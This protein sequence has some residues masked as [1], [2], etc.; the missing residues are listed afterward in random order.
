MR[1]NRR[2]LGWSSENGLHFGLFLGLSSGWWPLLSRRRGGEG[3]EGTELTAWQTRTFPP[4]QHRQGYAPDVTPPL[5]R[6][7]AREDTAW[8]GHKPV[9]EHH[10]TANGRVDAQASKLSPKPLAR[11]I[12]RVAARRWA[13][14]I[15]HEPAPARAILGA[16]GGPG[17]RSPIAQW[18]TSSGCDARSSQGRADA[19]NYRWQIRL[20][21]LRPGRRRDHHRGDC[22]QTAN[23]TAS[24][25][26][27]YFT[28]VRRATSRDRAVGVHLFDR[29]RR[30]F[31]YDADKTDDVT[32]AR[33]RQSR[34]GAD[35]RPFLRGRPRGLFARTLRSASRQ[36]LEEASA[37]GA[38]LRDPYLEAADPGGRRRET[39]EKLIED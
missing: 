37:Q 12:P 20:R 3:C 27:S 30:W 33:S 11:E 22:R 10:C 13:I 19:E 31:E 6:G 8:A 28:Q 17:R 1:G 7:A 18:T 39:G 24:E 9:Q 36:A 16:P 38:P 26:S 4:I 25:S 15:R 35:G 14:A 2:V 29:I 23:R 34:R 21:G 32:L 5:A